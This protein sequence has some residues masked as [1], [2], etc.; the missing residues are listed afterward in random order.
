MSDSLSVYELLDLREKIKSSSP[1]KMSALFSEFSSRIRRTYRDFSMNPSIVDT[2][3]ELFDLFWECI[4]QF[5]L[6]TLERRPSESF[7]SFLFEVFSTPRHDEDCDI[8]HVTKNDTA[9]SDLDPLSKWLSDIATLSERKFPTLQ[10]KLIPQISSIVIKKLNNIMFIIKSSRDC[11]SISK[12]FYE[13]RDY[14]LSIIF[15]FDSMHIQQYKSVMIQCFNC[16]NWMIQHSSPDCI[17]LPISPLISLIDSFIQ[18]IS[19]IHLKSEEIFDSQFLEIIYYIISNCSRHVQQA[20]VPLIDSIG[21]IYEEVIMKCIPNFHAIFRRGCVIKYVGDPSYHLFQSLNTIAEFSYKLRGS[22]LSLIKPYV[23]DWLQLYD[24]IQGKIFK[25]LVNCSSPSKDSDDNFGCC[26]LKS[27]IFEDSWSILPIVVKFFNDQFISMDQNGHI[28]QISPDILS[29]DRD[30]VIQFFS[31]LC[32]DSTHTVKV[33][34]VI[35]NILSCFTKVLRRRYIKNCGIE[36]LFFLLSSVSS[37]IPELS[38]KYDDFMQWCLENCGFDNKKYFDLYF[39][40]ICSFISTSFITN[41]GHSIPIIST[42]PTIETSQDPYF[43]GY[44]YASHVSCWLEFAISKISKPGYKNLELIYNIISGTEVLNHQIDFVKYSRK[45]SSSKSNRS[46]FDS[47]FSHFQSIFGEK[48]DEKD[49]DPGINKNHF[50]HS[51]LIQYTF[52]HHLVKMRCIEERSLRQSVYDLIERTGAGVEALFD[53]ETCSFEGYDQDGW[54]ETMRHVE[55]WKEE[56]R[57]EE[58]MFEY[59]ESE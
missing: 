19:R 37:L 1:E 4:F 26:S 54:R 45:A 33:F 39:P 43:D 38:P 32:F 14:F 8:R 51:S 17:F 7:Q 10:S 21:Y 15:A 48:E 25:V 5:V 49:N 24:K 59:S 34:E 46:E 6:L 27:G 57:E 22:I 47:F 42:I 29:Q 35:R 20:P 58:E 16:L 44:F 55:R 18:H 2:N 53:A 50:R 13:Y 11:D 41:L 40:S 9:S 56:E 31:N 36:K 12:I 23:K 28:S 30:Y 52:R 3:R